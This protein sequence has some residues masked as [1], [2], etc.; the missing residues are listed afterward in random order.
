[1][2]PFQ[3]EVLAGSFK[4]IQPQRLK[5]L[6]VSSLISCVLVLIL[7]GLIMETFDWVLGLIVVVVTAL[8][9]GL[10]ELF[11]QSRIKK[12]LALQCAYALEKYPEAVLYVPGLDRS[13]SMLSPRS[14]G[15]LFFQET[16]V[17]I[18]FKQHLLSPK[19]LDSLLVKCGSD[20]VLGTSTTAKEL[21]YVFYRSTLLGTE[22]E[23]GVLN[24]E[25]IQTKI[26]AIQS[27]APKEV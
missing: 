20:F 26:S 6:L 25:L 10:K 4:A 13:G 7:V 23:F 15:L 11:L 3:T 16:C 12:T 18:T 14:A 22:L 8:Y 17:L 5:P 24:S 19:P 21:P 2:S 1:M 9:M 27:D